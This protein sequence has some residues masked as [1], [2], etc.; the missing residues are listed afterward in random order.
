M[1]AQVAYSEDLAFI[2]ESGFSDLAEAA[3]RHVRDLVAPPALVVDIG[4]GGGTLLAELVRHGYDGF[5]VD[6]SP[7]MVDLARRRVR[8]ARIVVGSAYDAPLPRCRVVTAIGEVLGY[9]TGPR[10]EHLERVAAFFRRAGEALEPGGVLLFDVATT[11]RPEGRTEA[12]R[13]A[14]AW[15]VTATAETSD[16]VL[17]RTID[18]WRLERGSRRHGREAHRILLLDPE[19]VVGEL[20]AAGFEAER[21]AGYDDHPFQEGWDA[22][23]AQRPPL[24]APSGTSSARSARR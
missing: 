24:T 6:L 5:G 15:G 9:E 14:R 11:E 2:H 12:R 21:L 1:A 10:P 3:A 18:H 13:E 7:A 22:F 19:W 23:L 17:V 4:C 16:G 8:D 20:R